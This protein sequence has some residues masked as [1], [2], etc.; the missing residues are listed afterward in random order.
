MT[1]RLGPKMFT[2]ML[3]LIKMFLSHMD[4]NLFGYQNKSN[5]FVDAGQNKGKKGCVDLGQW[6][7]KAH[8]W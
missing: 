1:L 8:D 6:M 2:S 3:V 5:Q 4:P 7:L